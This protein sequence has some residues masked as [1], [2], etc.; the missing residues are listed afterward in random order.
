MCVNI[1][2]LCTRCAQRYICF[3]S[4]PLP[5]I[6]Y[7]TSIVY[8]TL[9][10]CCYRY[11][12]YDI[13]T[14]MGG[15]PTEIEGFYPA[16]ELDSNAIKCLSVTDTPPPSYMVNDVTF[17]VDYDIETCCTRRYAWAKDT[18]ISASREAAGS[19]APVSSPPTCVGKCYTFDSQEGEMTVTN[20]VNGGC[21][22]DAMCVTT[23][24]EAFPSNSPSRSPSKEVSIIIRGLAHILCILYPITYTICTNSLILLP[25]IIHI[26]SPLLLNHQSLLRRLLVIC[27]Q[28]NHHL[29]HQ[30]A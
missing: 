16:W 30:S 23:L 25:V 28:V 8:Q 5:S 18:C 24:K 4:Y 9:L 13:Q 3:S 1:R 15:K 7:H 11:Y 6:V 12:H 17:W 14:C 27:P 26:H 10:D 2:V 19:S 29:V 22:S 21:N 20:P